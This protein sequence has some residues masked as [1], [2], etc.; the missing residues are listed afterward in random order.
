MMGKNTEMLPIIQGRIIAV[1]SSMNSPVSKLK[2]P[3]SKDRALFSQSPTVDA[4]F[5]SGGLI[6]SDRIRI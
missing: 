6:G 3:G 2:I 5:S 4:H 1:N